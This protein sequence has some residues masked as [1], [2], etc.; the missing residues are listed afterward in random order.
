[1]IFNWTKLNVFLA[2]TGVLIESSDSSP[3]VR[4]YPDWG[5]QSPAEGRHIQYAFQTMNDILVNRHPLA[6]EML[7]GCYVIAAITLR[8]SLL[9]SLLLLLLLLL[10]PM[11][12]LFL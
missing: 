8:A 2:E 12:L 11:P 3:Q 9:L 10:L 4:H 1:M 6:S 5:A 7:G